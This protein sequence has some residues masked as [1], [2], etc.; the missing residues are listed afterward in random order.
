MKK[1]VSGTMCTILLICTF[2][3]CIPLARAETSS[4]GISTIYVWPASKVVNPSDLFTLYFNISGAP[5]CDFWN[6]YNITWDPTVIQ[7][8]H[9]TDA[10]IVEGP[11]FKAHGSTIIVAAGVN[12][13]K[14]QIW[15]I[16]CGF[17]SGG[18]A[19]GSGNLFYIKFKA[20]ANPSTTTITIGSPNPDYPAF[21]MLG[22][23]LADFPNLQGG[24][25][26]VGS[27]VSTVSVWPAFK[28]VSSPGDLFTLYVNITN[29]PTND[30]FDIYNITW[31]PTILGLEHGTY[32]DVVEGTFMKS[33]GTTVFAVGNINAGRIGEIACGFLTQSHAHGNGNLFSIKFRANVFGMSEIR[34][35]AAYLYDGQ[36]LVD[37]PFRKSGTV[38][39]GRVPTKISF[40]LVPNPAYAGTSV[41]LLGNLTTFNNLPVPSATVTIKSNGTAVASLKTNSTGWFKASGTVG[42]AGTYN[43]T[44]VYA[45]SSQLYPSS[46]WK[47]LTVISKVQTKI[48]ARIV[49]NPASPGATITLEGILIDKL[50]SSIISATISLQY[51]SN[52][53]STW[54]SLGT[55]TTNSYGIFTKTLTA[56][57]FGTYIY[58]MSYAGSS[59]YASTTTDIPLI[60][61]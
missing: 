57:S 21:L 25:V 3:S 40:S 22:P 37:Y 18:P 36:D 9:G 10:D 1:T 42:S 49:P 48:Y 56:P 27:Q 54:I 38:N 23:D 31:N 19:S 53:G 4:S 41:T 26:T 12:N 44:I 8:E 11:F 59:S 58:R 46:S 60:V 2:L 45:G 51:S 30:F 47:I 16:A 55:V 14:G 20:K 35:G 28:F 17:L 13:T 6:I 29:A 33:F 5:T 50:G 24:T 7:L 15:N 43:I 61:R 32:V 52:F 34:I 39:V